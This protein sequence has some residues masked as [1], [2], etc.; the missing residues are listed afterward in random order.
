M[1]QRVEGKM[2][3]WGRTVIE[4]GL[5]KEHVDSGWWKSSNLPVSERSVS[6]IRSKSADDGD[7]GEDDGKADVDAESDSNGSDEARRCNSG[8][9][10]SAIKPSADSKVYL[11]KLL[12]IDSHVKRLFLPI[13]SRTPGHTYTH[14]IRST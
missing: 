5:R 1:E 7:D 8:R 3:G 4:V 13:F 2:P 6:A 14:Y 12:V 11:A 10:S 9:H